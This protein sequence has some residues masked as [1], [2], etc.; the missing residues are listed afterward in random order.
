MDVRRQ[1]CRINWFVC[2]NLSFYLFIA[3][4]KQSSTPKSGI[5][6]TQIGSLELQLEQGDITKQTTD[7]IVNITNQTFNLQTGTFSTL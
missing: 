7:A 6:K 3:F 1:E 4:S 5:L 2:F